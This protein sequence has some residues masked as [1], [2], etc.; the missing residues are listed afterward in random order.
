MKRKSVSGSRSTVGQPRPLTELLT[1]LNRR[2]PPFVRLA[3]RLVFAV[4]KYPLG[5]YYTH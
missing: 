2:T 4:C 5:G 1:D 3:D